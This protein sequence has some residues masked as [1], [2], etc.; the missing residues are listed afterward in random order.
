MVALRPFEHGDIDALLTILNDT[1]VTRYLSSKIPSPYTASDATW[2]INE[3]SRQ[4]Y[5]RAV[6][7]DNVCV[8]CIGV[9]PGDFEYARSGE[10][11]YWLSR[12]VW[13]QGIMSKAIGQVCEDVFTKSDIVRIHAA[14]FSENTPSMRLLE[15]CGFVEEAVLQQAIFKLGIFYDKHVFALVRNK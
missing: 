6:T 1:D 9:V 14:V 8:G 12:S 10:I 13:R 3:G 4:G 15:K 11:G 5:V 2:W 7:L